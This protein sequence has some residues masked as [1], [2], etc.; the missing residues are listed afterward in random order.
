MNIKTTS[1]RE[2]NTAEE[3]LNGA[4]RSAEMVLPSPAV[5]AKPRKTRITN[6]LEAIKAR[7]GR[8]VTLINNSFDPSIA[9]TTNPN[10]NKST[11]AVGSIPFTVAPNNI[12]PEAISQ[13]IGMP[14]PPVL[15]P[16]I[17]VSM[18]MLIAINM[19]SLG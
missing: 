9:N 18:T 4:L 16:S 3:N 19:N 15:N 13:M 6:E 11:E 7:C 14:F 2:N 5:N 12:A 17:K 8:L 10:M 1:I